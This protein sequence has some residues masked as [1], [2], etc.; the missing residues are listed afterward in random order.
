MTD[1]IPMK[2]CGTLEE[3]ANMAAFIVSH[4]KQF[5]YRLHIRPFGGALLTD[6]RLLPLPKP[7]KITAL[8]FIS[9]IEGDMLHARDGVS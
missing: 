3:A 7:W 6:F 8:T 5:H 4:G 1:K 9:P 2:R